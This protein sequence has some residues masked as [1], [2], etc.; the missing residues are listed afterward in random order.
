MKINGISDKLKT[1]MYLVSM[2]LIGVIY[3]NLNDSDANTIRALDKLKKHEEVLKSVSKKIDA[4]NTQTSNLAS[5][6]DSLR[7]SI[8]VVATILLEMNAIYVSELESINESISDVKATID[9]NEV[10]YNDI[11]TDLLLLE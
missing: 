5:D 3:S 1:A 10:M 4:Y 2:V 9:S 11:K 8:D 6:M 7:I